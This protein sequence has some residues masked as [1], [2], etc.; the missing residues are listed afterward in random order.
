[1]AW[2]CVAKKDVD[3]VKKCMKCRAPDHEVD[4]T[5][6]GQR[7]FKKIVKHINWTGRTTWSRY[8]S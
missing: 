8:N 5:A 7:L 2:V 1:M 6:I 4:Q 3:W